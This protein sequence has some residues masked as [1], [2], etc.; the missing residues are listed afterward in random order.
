L[1][2][3]IVIVWQTNMNNNFKRTQFVTCILVTQQVINGF[4]IK[5]SDLLDI[6]QAELQLAVTQSYFNYNA[7]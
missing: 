1:N 5:W 3:V 7:S 6:H 4:W 2:F